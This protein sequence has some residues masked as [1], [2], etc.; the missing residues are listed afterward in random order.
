MDFAPVDALLAQAVG[1]V[2]PAA[3]LVVL[4]RGSSVLERAAGECDAGTRF[5]V[6]SLTKPLVTT[7]LAMRLIQAGKLALT[8]EVRPGVTVEHA[9]CHATGLPAW[10]PL[11]ELAGEADDLRAAVVEAARREPLECAPGTR[12][13]YSDLGFILLGDAIERA[14]GA[15]LDAQWAP[16]AEQLAI[17]AR[18][19]PDGRCAPARGAPGDDPELDLRC[20]VHD[21]NALAMEGVAGHA[22]LFATADAVAAIA[23][24]LVDDWRDGSGGLVDGGLLRRFWS[25]CGVPGS[26]WCL[27]W[28]RP[29][30]SGSQAGERWP[31]D[32]VGHLG[33]TGCSLWIDPP[34][35]RAVALLSNRVYLPEA[36][37]AIKSLRP[38][39]HDAIV[40][41]L[42]G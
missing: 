5:D 10:R 16:I 37:D 8:D 39:L 19:H 29:S 33:F 11:H 15:R 13:L 42:D 6:A 41:A 31:R 34:R 4:D 23:A 21:D 3:Q 40:A 14:G 17:D 25:P 2:F 36:G 38:R 20:V 18:F 1:R 9:L 30:P 27:G 32:G 12:S 24:K 28:D 22:G 26:T 35:G 7:T